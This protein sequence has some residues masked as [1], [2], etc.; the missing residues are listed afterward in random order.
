MRAIL[1]L[2]YRATNVAVRLAVC[3]WNG[4]ERT[5]AIGG[6]CRACNATLPDARHA[7]IP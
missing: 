4:H 2:V 7:M 6:R 1:S 5:A 3:S